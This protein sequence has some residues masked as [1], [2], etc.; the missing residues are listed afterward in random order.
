MIGHGVIELSVIMMAG[1][2]GLKLGWAIIHPGLLHLFRALK[3]AASRA[4]YLVIGCLPLLMI[5][6]VIEGF[7][8]PAENIPWGIKW[9]VGLATGAG[10]YSYLFFAGRPAK[11]KSYRIAFPTAESRA[12]NFNSD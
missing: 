4:V 3:S 12:F 6:G 10:T 8:S 5:A 9:L 7:S 1:G 11:I 2:A